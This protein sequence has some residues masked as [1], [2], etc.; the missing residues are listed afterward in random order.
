MNVVL[1]ILVGIVIGWV[2]EWV[3]DWLFWRKDDSQLQEKLNRAEAELASARQ[4]VSAYQG[5]LAEARPGART[6]RD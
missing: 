4:E 3:I 6:N 2:I 5:R 1:W